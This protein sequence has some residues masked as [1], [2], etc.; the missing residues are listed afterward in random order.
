MVVAVAVV[1]FLLSLE[2]LPTR[3]TVDVR[4]VLAVASMPAVEFPKL[5]PPDRARFGDW[6]VSPSEVRARF[7]PGIFRGAVRSD[8]VDNFVLES[9]RWAVLPS[10][11]PAL[12][13]SV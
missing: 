10:F 2:T 1:G 13:L 3:F 5:A 7:V 12:F 8:E 6:T 11:K 9:I 4:V